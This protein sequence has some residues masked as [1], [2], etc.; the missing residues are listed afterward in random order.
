MR[1]HAGKILTGV[2]AAL[3]CALLILFPLWNPVGDRGSSAILYGIV[4]DTDEA[5]SGDRRQVIVLPG[6]GEVE[7]P[8]AKRIEPYIELTDFDGLETGDLV[9]LTF[10][11]D[12]GIMETWPGQF[13]HAAEKIEVMGRGSFALEYAGGD[14]YRL[15]FPAGM[16]Q[17]K[18]EDIL[19]PGV[20]LDFYLNGDGN[21]LKGER[22]ALTPLQGLNE[23]MEQ[24]WVEF[25][26]EQTE[27]FLSGYGFGLTCSVSEEK[28]QEPDR[29]EGVN[30]V[31][32]YA[33]SGGGTE[34]EAGN[35]ADGTV[36]DGIYTLRVRKLSQEERAV[37]DYLLCGPEGEELTADFAFSEDCLFL[38]NEAMDTQEYRVASFEEFASLME[39]AYENQQ[40]PVYVKFQDGVITEAYLPSAYYPYGIELREIS[41][42]TWYEDASKIV[43]L[44]GEDMLD[45]YYTLADTTQADVS[46]REGSEI[47]ETYTGNIGD[48]D[49]GIVLVRTAG[50]EVL[51]SM[52]ALGA[53]A[54]WNN[55]YLGE[56]DGQAYLMTLYIEDRDDYG[57][58]GYEV[59]RLDGDGV[60][61]RIAGS[62]FE[63]QTGRL[64][65]DDGLFREWAEHLRVYMENSR[66]LLSSQEQQIRTEH[67]CEADK[68]NYETLRRQ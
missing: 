30:N 20:W 59:F 5:E 27:L 26:R 24:A 41:A 17:G 7:I 52:S 68:Y 60:P 9:R 51:Y 19:E 58:Y 40:M 8:E 50:G 32:M 63:W 4:A 34:L 66:L 57:G 11:E 56:L 31:I 45:A 2:G 23:E 44:D 3:F 62:T 10:A 12:V 38:V 21:G 46:D 54:G 43:G 61:V 18:D 1:K 15:A 36:L 55:I 42:D 53:R 67:V 48:G 49:G 14:V 29:E 65:Y 33:L 16:I 6:T 64:L 22:F 35:M 25:D 13:D 28:P 47:L 37:K 39:P